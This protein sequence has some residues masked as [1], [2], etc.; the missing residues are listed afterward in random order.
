MPRFTQEYIEEETGEL[1][2]EPDN[3]QGGGWFCIKFSQ[4]V[5]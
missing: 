1:S 5:S 4:L 3:V 2:E